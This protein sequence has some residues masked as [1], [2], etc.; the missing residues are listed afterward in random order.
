M[1]FFI[2]LLSVVSNIL[3]FKFPSWIYYFG[4][5]WLLGVNGAIFYVVSGSDFLS[6]KRKFVV[7]SLSLLIVVYLWWVVF[8]EQAI[9]RYVLALFVS[10]IIFLGI[11]LLVLYKNASV[12]E[13]SPM[14]NNFLGYVNVFSFFCLTI[15]VLF[16][17][18]QFLS[19]DAWVFL[20]GV[21]YGLT[22]LLSF[23]ILQSY[24][25]QR[26]VDRGNSR[27]AFHVAW[28]YTG[29]AEVVII[30]FSWVL[31]LLLL[32]YYLQA[33]FLFLIY[34]LTLG[35]LRQYI[36]FGKAGIS[37]RVLYKYLFFFAGGLI[38]LLATFFGKYLL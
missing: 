6:L 22:A 8:I 14:L 18:G 13:S 7:F 35:I 17:Q 19:V 2:L 31:G 21:Y 34:Y 5:V 38:L 25:G 15:A 30:Q 11:R 9:M 23:S 1:S 29:I 28:F 24:H 27:L 32:D 37:D 3:I 26:V 16:I 33:A 20:Y 10:F 12:L 36:V 4:I